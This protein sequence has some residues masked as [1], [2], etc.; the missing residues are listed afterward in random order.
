[1]KALFGVLF[2]LGIIAAIVYGYVANIISLMTVNE[3][4][5]VSIL[6]FVGIFF[7]PIGVFIGY[8]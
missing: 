6:R 7:V 5:V 3:S 2:S 1:M 8:F 4:V